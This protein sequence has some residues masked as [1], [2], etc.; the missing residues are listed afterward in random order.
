MTIKWYG[1]Q[2]LANVRE[3]ARKAIDETTALASDEAQGI[4]GREAYKT[5][6]YQGSIFPEPA[7]INGNVV[8]G[9]WGSHDIKYAIWLEIGARGRPGLNI[10]RR[11][12]DRFATPEQVAERIFKYLKQAR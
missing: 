11:S 6:A 3:A 4:A 2:V 10:L 7:E 1:D 5:G 12:Q 8:T 9:L